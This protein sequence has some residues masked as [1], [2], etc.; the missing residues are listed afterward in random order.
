MPPGGIGNIIFVPLVA[1]ALW[2]SLPK[3]SDETHLTV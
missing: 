1:I 3:N 2:F